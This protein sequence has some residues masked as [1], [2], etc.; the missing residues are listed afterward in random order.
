ML[1]LQDIPGRDFKPIRT[2]FGKS[3][4]FNCPLKLCNNFISFREPIY[5]SK[6]KK[7]CFY[8]NIWNSGNNLRILKFSW[9]FEVDIYENT[10]NVWNFRDAPHPHHPWT[11]CHSRTH[12]QNKQFVF[13]S[14]KLCSWSFS[15][16]H[17]LLRMS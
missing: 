17:V 3:F 10:L 11:A 1:A 15:S 4:I 14:N 16:V 2:L 13:L 5:F 6:K 8:R 9:S 7:K 12:Y